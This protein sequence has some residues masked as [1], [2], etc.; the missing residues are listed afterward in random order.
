[1]LVKE[2]QE[3]GIKYFQEGIWLMP[4]AYVPE[5]RKVGNII[6]VP[7]EKLGHQFVSFYESVMSKTQYL[8]EDHFNSLFEPVDKI[9]HM[10]QR[11]LSHSHLQGKH[12]YR[13]NCT[14]HRLLVAA[15]STVN[16]RFVKQ[17]RDKLMR[18]FYRENENYL[19]ISSIVASPHASIMITYCIQIIY[20]TIF[21]RYVGIQV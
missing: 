15:N 16:F 20:S 17:K 10:H 7:K 9:R 6:K 4:K 14:K 8:P 1:M 5:T 3:D 21:T 11:F 13:Q 12:D 18:I 2:S 19:Y